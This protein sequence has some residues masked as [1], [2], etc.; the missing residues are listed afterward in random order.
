M[1]GNPGAEGP[2]SIGAGSGASVRTDT[3]VPLLDPAELPLYGSRL[4]EASAGTGKTFTIAALYLRLVLGHGGDRAFA[5]ALLP[6]RILVV[7]F[8]DAATRELRARIHER[9]LG[10]ARHFRG[11]AP[12][13]PDTALRRLLDDYP[14][15]L[16]RQRCARQLELAAEWM[17]EA[18]VSTIHGW[19]YRMLREHAFDSGS[20]FEQQ[21]ETDLSE[22]RAEAVRDYWRHMV[23]PQQGAR[24]ELLR[25]ILGP[26][27]DTLD[28]RIRRLLAGEPARAAPVSEL[29]DL[30]DRRLAQLEMVKAPWRDDFEAAAASFRVAL[31]GL[32]GNQY[33]RPDDLLA[34]MRAWALDPVRAQ[35]GDPKK[36]L[37]LRFSLS[38]M[39]ARLKKGCALP[40][41]PHPAFARLDGYSDAVD[42]TPAAVLRH[43]AAW[44]RERFEREQRRRAQ[45]GFD[46]LLNGLDAALA[47]PGGARLAETIRG[48]FPVAM[49]DE[50][51]DTDPVQYRIFERIYRVA[52]NRPEQGVFLIGDP[53]QSIYSFRGADI[54][55]YLRA[56]R[57]TTGRHYT[58]K[59]NFRASTAVV[60][61]CNRLFGHAE[62]HA[63]G[64]FLF[65]SPEGRNPVPF[66]LVEA[67]GRPEV[68]R[69][70]GRD[71]PALTLAHL[72]DAESIAKG[73]YVRQMAARCASVMVSLLEAGR[74]GEAG[75]FE[76]GRPTPLLPSDLAV[77][78]R[79]RHEAGAIRAALRRRGVRSV[80]LSDRESIF[81]TPEAA[82]VLRWLRACAEPESDRLLR[83][84]LATATLDLGLDELDRLNSDEA[85]WEERVLQFRA[86]RQIWRDQG[87]L[88][89]LR[90]LLHD[91][92]L[93]GALFHR[94]DGERVL[95]NLLHLSE[96]LQTAAGELDGEQGLVRH[97]AEHLQGNGAAAEEQ[98]L[99]LESD[100]GL[101]QV[102][103]IH[104]A[105]GLQYPLVFLPFVCGFRPVDA[106][107]LPVTWHDADGR[108][109]VRWNPEPDDVRQADRER[110][111]EDLRLLY[112]AVTRAR[113]HCWLGIGPL[114][115]GNARNHQLHL[116]AIGHLLSG[117]AE[118]PAGELAGALR[119]L[120]GEVPGIAVLPTPEPT[121]AVYRPD[122][123]AQPT[124]APRQPSRPAREHWWIA[125]YSALRIGESSGPGLPAVPQAADTA[126]EDRFSE[127]ADEP[128]VDAA[129]APPPAAAG[130]HRFPRGP[131]P[132]TF[133]HG[134]L[135][136]AAGEGLGAIAGAPERLRDTV[137]RR[138]RRRGWDHWVDTLSDWLGRLLTEPLELPG[139]DGPLRLCDLAVFQPELEFWFETHWVNARR[140]DRAVC[141]LTLDAA[142]RPEV[143]PQVLNGMLKGFIDLVFE[144]QG[145]YYTLDYK[146]NWLGPRAED[147]APA[148]MRER[149][150]ESRYDLQYV[151]YSLAL[152]RLLRARLPDYDYDRHVGGTVTWFLRG[153]DAPG[154]GLHLERPT[155]ALIE[156]L[157]AMI[158]SAPDADGEVGP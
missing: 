92:A 90:R 1:N 85:H 115:L 56:R 87:V 62:G 80:Y 8:T 15:P 46:D 122:K 75:F 98:I 145:R 154:R 48:Q 151:L 88:P 29:D 44:V 13:A 40:P 4:I 103:T 118:I 51:Q 21:L 68:L 22:L 63:P 141:A 126:L 53:K 72:D 42:D 157:D 110:L 148:R 18:A 124:G 135:E 14:D 47:G 77:L 10:A 138:C 120:A 132:G 111:A 12:G 101:V 95:T 89:M 158:R 74:T 7:T 23:Y 137:A 33:R 38:G 9:L 97:L 17:D 28:R 26:D 150:L 69:V 119:A 41:D 107:R 3:A 60:A 108:L 102:V 67:A 37:S 64:A 54:H 156:E 104:K 123:D 2:A 73:E 143:L 50:F 114:R 147:Y 27:P 30:L 142:P 96:L 117:G 65:R 61:A 106:K 45:L 155:R 113:H 5:E 153:L 66:E 84:A 149:V 78:V 19:C 127:A 70:E 134:L 91:F 16:E 130:L 81:D 131:G 32:N 11:D 24:L 83:A 133:L 109:Q 20:L 116:T 34:A 82:D 58:L 86:Y 49:I 100:E 105:K 76:E 79:D 31:P 55:S 139:S 146:S 99:R 152:H 94:A 35:P 136:W 59:V 129:R 57:D 121:E 71:L 93:P 128:P 125:S 52:E 6:P 144:H 39:R 25:A 140:L 36:P 112:V 43:A